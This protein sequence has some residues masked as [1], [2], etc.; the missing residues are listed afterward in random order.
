MPTS[1]LFPSHLIISAPLSSSPTISIISLPLF[2][3]CPTLIGI[4]IPMFPPSSSAFRTIPL[5]FI[6]SFSALLCSLVIAS[7][8]FFLPLTLIDSLEFFSHWRAL[9]IQLHVP[10]ESPN[11]ISVSSSPPEPASLSPLPTIPLKAN[12]AWSSLPIPFMSILIFL[13][14]ASSDRFLIPNPPSST[15]IFRTSP[16]KLFML[17]V[18]FLMILFSAL[19]NSSYLA[20]FHVQNWSLYRTVDFRHVLTTSI[21]SLLLDILLFIISPN[22]SIVVFIAVHCLSPLRSISHMTPRC[23]I[24]PSFFTS[25][26]VD[27]PPPSCNIIIPVS[28]PSFLTPHCLPNVRSLLIAIF[29]PVTMHHPDIT[30][31]LSCSCFRDPVTLIRSSANATS[32]ASFDLPFISCVLKSL[33]ISAS[34][35]SRVSNAATQSIGEG[36]S[37]CPTPFPLLN[38]LPLLSSSPFFISS[39]L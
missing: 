31:A 7:S 17:L 15:S 22:L 35:V 8:A 1:I 12:P 26:S 3:H 37:P 33:L 29:I 25:T 34:A 20:R 6:I 36:T 19:S 38:P 27:F 32:F 23:V 39:M 28:F 14:L 18:T 10:S 13:S 24:I 21:L 4:S 30:S 16:G 11:I 5:L 2:Q 9:V